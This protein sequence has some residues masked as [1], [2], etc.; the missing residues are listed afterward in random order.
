MPWVW[1]LV[2]IPQIML[3]HCR[4][5][6]QQVHCIWGSLQLS[7][8]QNFTLY[9][10]CAYVYLPSPPTL[11]PSSKYPVLLS[12]PPSCYCL[13][14]TSPSFFL[15]DC[16]HSLSN[17]HLWGFQPPKRW[18]HCLLLSLTNF[19]S[20]SFVCCNVVSKLWLNTCSFVCILYNHFISQYWNAANAEVK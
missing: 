16:L 10:Q 1:N 12:W 6:L 18:L 7:R 11:F 8:G 14:S 9:E 19:F 17:L 13:L 15:F 20:P 3:H 2:W 5:E 4:A